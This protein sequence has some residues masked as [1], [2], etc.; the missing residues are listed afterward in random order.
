M[1]GGVMVGWGRVV[2]V[3][4]LVDGGLVVGGGGGC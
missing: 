2:G 1:V 3:R 4:V